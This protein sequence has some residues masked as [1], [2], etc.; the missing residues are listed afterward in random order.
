VIK[1]LDSVSIQLSVPWDVLY[2]QRQKTNENYILFFTILA[3][4]P[5]SKYGNRELFSLYIYS[6]SQVTSVSEN[7]FPMLR[8]LRGKKFIFINLSFSRTIL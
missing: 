4:P 7:N 1:V 6:A 3:N 5:T 8:I 2:L